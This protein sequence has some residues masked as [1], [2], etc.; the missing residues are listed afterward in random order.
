MHL[1]Q[2]VQR[3]EAFHVPVA[4]A[5][6][7]TEASGRAPYTLTAHWE[8]LWALWVWIWSDVRDAVLAEVELR[9]PAKRREV[10]ELDD[11]IVLKR[12][13]LERAASVEMH[14]VRCE[15]MRQGVDAC[16]F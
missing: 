14:A 6:Q 5:A 2:L 7:S 16:V 13:L 12:E 10:L 15:C 9:Q 3:L 11:A 1:G 8:D 4:H